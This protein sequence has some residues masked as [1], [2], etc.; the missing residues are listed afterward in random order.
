MVLRSLR[1]VCCILSGLLM[2][3]TSSAHAELVITEIMSQSAHAGSIDW[4]EITNT[5]AA[6]VDLSGYQWEDDTARNPRPAFPSG[7]SIAPGESIVVSNNQDPVQFR[8]NWGLAESVQVLIVN[9]PGLG[10]NDQVN[11]Y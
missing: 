7:V 1:N 4:F 8:S 5:G 2:V 9:G 10:S 11:L 6:A 3:A